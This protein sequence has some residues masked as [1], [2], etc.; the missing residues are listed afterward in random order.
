MT[1][2][3]KSSVPSFVCEMPWIWLALLAALISFNIYLADM[4][5]QMRGD[6]QVI[7]KTVFDMAKSSG[8]EDV[9]EK[10]ER[11]HRQI[12]PIDSAGVSTDRFD[13]DEDGGSVRVP[14]ETLV[15]GQE[16]STSITA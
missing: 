12:H 11:D 5:I 2:A 1:C 4:L 10:E 14:S 16:V 13:V 3:F 6:V 7:R 9:D 8:F 15:E